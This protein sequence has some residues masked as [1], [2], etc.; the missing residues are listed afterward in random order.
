MGSSKGMNLEPTVNAPADYAGGDAV[1]T[2]TG[3]DG[4]ELHRINTSSFPVEI[5][6]YN[7]FAI[8]KGEITITYNV[9]RQ[10]QV[11][12]AAGNVTVQTV[13]VLTTSAPIPV[14]FTRA[15]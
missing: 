4:S 3:V 10:E 6:L 5:N 2:L 13:Q 1:I 15:Q 14:N 7:I 9:N 12:D 11:T 8:S